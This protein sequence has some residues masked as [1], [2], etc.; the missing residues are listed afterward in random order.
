MEIIIFI[1]LK[2]NGK[3]EKSKKSTKNLKCIYISYKYQII[4]QVIRNKVFPQ[5]LHY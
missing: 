4:T 2:K 1:N 5:F 3:Q